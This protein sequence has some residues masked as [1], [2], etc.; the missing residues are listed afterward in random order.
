[1]RPLLYN[2]IT[3]E[4]YPTLVGWR[5]IPCEILSSPLYSMRFR[6][7]NMSINRMLRRFQVIPPQIPF[8]Y[9]VLLILIP[10]HLAM[11]NLV[12]VTNLWNI[13]TLRSL[14][15]SILEIRKPSIELPQN[16]GRLDA[17][18][19]ICG[20]AIAHAFHG[21]VDAHESLHLFKCDGCV[22]VF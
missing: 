19:R 20:G 14:N 13:A 1:M 17:L 6:Y 7:P 10:H 11:P 3:K 8:V 21:T 9:N 2:I 5:T 22:F 15:K 4:N 16:R 18:S 12:L